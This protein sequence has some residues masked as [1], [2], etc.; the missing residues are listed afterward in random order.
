VLV[1]IELQG[2]ELISRHS[3]ATGMSIMYFIFFIFSVLFSIELWG[4]ESMSYH[5]S[6]IGMSTLFATFCIAAA[7]I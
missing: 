6:A 2:L 7:C 5:N 1:S 4:L 3:S